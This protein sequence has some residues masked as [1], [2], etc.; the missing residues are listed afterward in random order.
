MSDTPQAEQAVRQATFESRLRA[1]YRGDG[2]RVWDAAFDREG[3]TAALAVD[4]GTV[5]IWTRRPE[6]RRGSL[7]RDNAR[8]AHRNVLFCLHVLVGPMLP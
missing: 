8:C 7:G 1:A 3:R 6:P 5:R 4:D 2:G